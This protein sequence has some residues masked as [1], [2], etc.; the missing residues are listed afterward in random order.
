[1]HVKFGLICYF[2]L[3]DY[4]ST[5]RKRKRNYLKYWVVNTR[6]SSSKFEILSGGGEGFILTWNS[7]K[8]L[9]VYGFIE[10]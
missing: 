4:E 10:L 6:E 1:M 9:V 8:L 3:F 2:S 5:L 7:F